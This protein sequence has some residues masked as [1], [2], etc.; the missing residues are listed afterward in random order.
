M[1]PCRYCVAPKR[2]PGCKSTCT[3]YAEWL[4]GELERKE[5]IRQNREKEKFEYNKNIRKRSK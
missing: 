3:E 2:H 1:T 5:N 4:P